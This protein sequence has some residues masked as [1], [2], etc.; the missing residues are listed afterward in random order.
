MIGCRATVIESVRELMLG[1]Y[2]DPTGGGLELIEAVGQLLER[3]HNRRVRFMN[4]CEHQ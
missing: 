3:E 4:V 1:K 2:A